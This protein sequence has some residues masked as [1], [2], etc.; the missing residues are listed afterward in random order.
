[1]AMNGVVNLSSR[2]LSKE[3]VS[4]L[5][6]GLTFCPTPPCPEPRQAMEDLD[7]LYRRM[8]LLAHF[9]EKPSG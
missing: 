3:E 6:R 9:E 4:L 1:M 5:Q 8:R 2:P 7:A